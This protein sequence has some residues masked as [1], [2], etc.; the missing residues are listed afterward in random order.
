M[1]ANNI[2]S[3]IRSGF[4]A[5][6]FGERCVEEVSAAVRERRGLT[7]QHDASYAAAVTMM[8]TKLGDEGYFARDFETT[9]FSR[10]YRAHFLQRLFSSEP[11]PST[12]CEV[13]FG[14][15][16]SALLFLHTLASGTVHSF[17]HGLARYTIPA[18]NYLDEAYPERMTLTLGDSAVVVP[19]LRHYYP[20]A[21]CD[22]V[23][24]DGSTTYEGEST[25]E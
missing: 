15:G 12:Y 2:C 23:Y 3:Q 14:A 24:L 21:K 9:L 20:D 10:P 1:T 7:L 18:H 11:H 19:Q 17:D 25:E 8:E 13:G 6:E 16:H 22:V 4:D 5:G